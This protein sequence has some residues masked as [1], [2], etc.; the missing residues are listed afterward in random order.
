MIS[1]DITL[2]AKSPKICQVLSYL[3]SKYPLTL[4]TSPIR[5]ETFPCPGT[6]STALGGSPSAHLPC[7]RGSAPLLSHHLLELL[8]LRPQ[9]SAALNLYTI[10]GY[11]HSHPRDQSCWYLPSSS[12]VHLSIWPPDIITKCFESTSNQNTHH[13]VPH[14]GQPFGSTFQ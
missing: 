3:T 5:S 7:L 13:L 9:T 8:R 6:L 2:F 4:L 11:F 10:P 1:V 12:Q 14:P